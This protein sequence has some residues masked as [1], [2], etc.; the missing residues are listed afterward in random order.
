M[1]DPPARDLDP[2]ILGYYG[3]APEES[4]LEHDAFRLESRLAPVS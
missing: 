2:A 4:R 3:T 1:T